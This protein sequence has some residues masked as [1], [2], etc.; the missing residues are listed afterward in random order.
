MCHSLLQV[1][2]NQPRPKRQTPPSLAERLKE[3][4]RIKDTAWGRGKAQCLSTPIL[5]SSCSRNVCCGLS[6]WPEM[7]VTSAW[8]ERGSGDPPPA[9][10]PHTLHPGEESITRRC[11]LF[12]PFLFFE[13]Q[14]TVM[15]MAYWRSK[16]GPNVQPFNMAAISHMGYLNITELKF[17]NVVLRSLGTFQV[18]T[19]LPGLAASGCHLGQC[20]YSTC[21][22]AEAFIGQCCSAAQC[23]QP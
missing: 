11:F 2:K 19:G 14:V 10:R 5:Q 9:V 4:M 7:T 12:L 21:I 1:L 18:L 17:K 16:K 6:H 13:R 23:L 22:I 8:G 20:R 3:M 15:W